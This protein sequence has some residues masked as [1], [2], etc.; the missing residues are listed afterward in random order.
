MCYGEVDV[1]F[2]ESEFNDLD[3]KKYKHKSIKDNN[4]FLH[5]IKLTNKRVFFKVSNTGKKS[6]YFD[7][8]G[9]IKKSLRK[10]QYAEVA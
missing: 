9:Y 5:Y 1:D 4:N 6:A 2:Y 8:H 7:M 3:S 10:S